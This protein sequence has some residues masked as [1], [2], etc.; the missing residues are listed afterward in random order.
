MPTSLLRLLPL[1]LLLL[2]G[3]TSALDT[4]PERLLE[5][6]SDDLDGMVERRTVRAL[7]SWSK[8]DYFILKGRQR[9]IA[10]EAARDFE[11]FI[12]RNVKHGR[13]PVSVVLIPVA[14]DKLIS[15]LEEGRGD[16]AFAGLRMVPSRQGRMDFSTPLY[17][18]SN[19]IVVRGKDVPAVT[20]LDDLSGRTFHLRPSSSY[21]K[22]LEDLN[23]A[24][25]ARGLKPA[26]IE[27][28][29]EHLADEDI[30]ELIN[31][32]LIEQT[33]LDDFR[34]KLWAEV[35]PD[36]VSETA[37]PLVE[38]RPLVLGLRRN[39]PKFKALVDR[40]VNQHKIGTTYG[41]VLARR[42]FVSNTWAR[43]ALAPAE[44]ARFR[45][46]VDLFKRY[47][48]KYGFDYLMLT[49]QGFQESGLEQ[50]TRSRAGAIGV[51]QVMPATGRAM[52]VGDIHKLE[53]NI[54]AGVKYMNHLADVYFN[55]DKLD[56]IN[57]TL[58]CFAA[59]NAGPTRIASLRR[60]AAARGLDP[61]I[62]FD[63]VERVV[64]EKVGQETVQYV[65]NISKYFVAYKLVEEQDRKREAIKASLGP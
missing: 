49:A 1:L 15:Y 38:N 3:T 8:T 33:I 53:P 10:Y 22:T 29:D 40:F 44:L 35:F 20:S 19:E 63:N 37:T 36:V 9:G 56:P 21:R 6:Q 27:A 16:I 2:C 34:A 61:N 4:L 11:K 51:M 50:K 28:L 54:H 24:F 12:N 7:V 60:L 52:Q 45:N 23:G 17:Q 58:L 62:W 26:T 5:P 13:R 65:V 42:Y 18:S 48:E 14:R 46:M 30:L 39:T 47:G 41:N 43:N 57:R 31:A 59:Y 25:K 64:A 55:D 32:G